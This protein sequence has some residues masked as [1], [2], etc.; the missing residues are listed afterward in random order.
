MLHLYRY[1]T[2]ETRSRARLYRAVLMTL[3]MVVMMVFFA[4]YA[5]LA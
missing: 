3:I 5:L 1:L 2:D 4:V